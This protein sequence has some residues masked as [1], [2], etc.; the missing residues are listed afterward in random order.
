MFFAYFLFLSLVLTLI[1][2]AHWFVYFSAI[3]LLKIERRKGIKIFFYLG[4]FTSFSFI[5]ASFLARVQ[6]S[7]L[8]R[9]AYITSSLWLGYLTNFIWACIILWVLKGLYLK[10]K[11]HFDFRKL[12][13]AVFSF[14]VLFA[15]WGIYHASDVK[16]KNLNIAMKNLPASWEGKRVMQL[17]DT[18]FGQIYGVGAVQKIINIVNQEKPD[19][20]VITG[21][22]FDGTDGNM[23]EITKYVGLIKAPMGVYFT[24]GNHDYY[25]GQEKVEADLTKVGI[26]VLADGFVDLDGLQLAGI[27]YS[28]PSLAK[29]FASYTDEIKSWPSY[30]VDKPTV[31]M[32]HIPEKISEFADGGIDLML[33]GHTH[34][35]QIFPF[36]L[37]TDIIF[38]G[39]DHGLNTYK[40]LQVYTSSGT[41]T[42]GPPMR[43][44]A[45]SEIVIFK[46]LKK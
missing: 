9:L 14:F 10:L 13:I 16:V 21:D 46:L 26:K 35:G 12:S 40:D 39:F 43:T 18:H 2:G 29:K 3:R 6:G 15:S 36:G 1:L 5:L 37:I 7:P 25:A 31:M 30:S 4:L 8:I 42:W 23:D 27:N 28:F 33:S 11:L 19:V 38:K 20:V 41:G 24:S 22:L 45:D 32:H 44:S 34:R 17:S